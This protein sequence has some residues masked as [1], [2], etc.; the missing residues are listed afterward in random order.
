MP[1]RMV[2]TPGLDR[3]AAMQRTPVGASRLLAPP[4]A[5]SSQYRQQASM[6]GQALRNL[7]RAARRGDA[8]AGILALDVRD[9]ANQEGF[10]PGGIRSHEAFQGDIA[11][12]EQSYQ[13]GA[14]D[15]EATSQINRGRGVSPLV[16]GRQPASGD[17]FQSS[18]YLAGV[19]RTPTTDT[20]ESYEETTPPT[21]ED[22]YE[23][24]G[25]QLGRFAQR[26]WGNTLMNASSNSDLAARSL[27]FRQGLDRALG[28][29]KTA[30][31]RTDLQAAA[32]KAGISD[33]A[34]NR[35]ANWWDSNRR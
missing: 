18:G 17:R 5:V 6:Y 8:K 33:E 15:L 12:R 31:E 32:R 35:R 1:D 29:A 3:L 7:N 34:F 13:Q 4:S 9:K 30:G 24:A 19:G 22:G 26:A 11:G 25:S 16:T 14:E 21:P 28:Q 10:T 23:P 2:D 27:Q 20:P